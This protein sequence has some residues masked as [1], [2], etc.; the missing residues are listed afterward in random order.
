M[1][2]LKFMI[3]ER[4]LNLPTYSLSEK[5]DRTKSTFIDS[6]RVDTVVRIPH[7]L[8]VKEFIQDDTFYKMIFETCH[9]ACISDNKIVSLSCSGS[10]KIKLYLERFFEKNNL[11]VIVDSDFKYKFGFFEI[12]IKLNKYITFKDI[13]NAYISVLEGFHISDEDIKGKKLILRKKISNEEN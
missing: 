13:G 12:K 8:D 2:K 9:E 7:F 5:K 4:E 11:G 6:N 3:F 10:E 1:I